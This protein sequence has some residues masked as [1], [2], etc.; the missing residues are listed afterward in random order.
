MTLRF[1]IKLNWEC[2]ISIG[3]D[4]EN[5]EN[6]Q[7]NNVEFSL[8]RNSEN[9]SQIFANS[10]PPPN[11]SQLEFDQAVSDSA[12]GNTELRETTI[13]TTPSSDTVTQPP[14]YSDVIRNEVDFH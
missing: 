11:Y 3:D 8:G 12:N 5:R 6:A 2:C 1:C 14:S 7:N 9:N 10:P 13:E 4:E